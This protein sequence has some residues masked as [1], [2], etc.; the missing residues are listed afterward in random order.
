[1]ETGK[2]EHLHAALAAMAHDKRFTQ[3]DYHSAIRFIIEQAA[4]EIGCARVS[5][6]A[7]EASPEPQIT[8]L[9]LWSEGA[10]QGAGTVL[11]H[12]E[13]SSYLASLEKDVLLVMN[14]VTC[15]PRCRELNRAYLPD[16][17]ILSMMDAPFQFDGRLAGVICFE[18]VGRHRTW[19]T[20]EQ[21]FASSMASLLSIATERHHRRELETRLQEE[22]GR[23]QMLLDNAPVGIIIVVDDHLAYANKTLADLAGL[24]RTDDLIGVP[25]SAFLPGDTLTAARERINELTLTRSETVSE[26]TE[27]KVVFNGNEYQLEMTSTYINWRGRDAVQS[28]IRDVT[29]Q[30]RAEAEAQETATRLLALIDSFPGGFAYTDTSFTFL[31]VNE[32]LAG[33]A[34]MTPEQMV[35]VPASEL[36]TSGFLGET[37]NHLRRVMAGEAV[38]FERRLNLPGDPMEARIYLVPHFDEAN[39]IR[40]MFT[41]VTDIRELRDTEMALRQA[42]K[43]EAVGQLTGGIAHDFNNILTIVMGNLEVLGTRIEGTDN[44]GLVEDALTGARRGAE[45]TRKLLGFS[46]T[47]TG[48]VVITD[49]NRRVDHLT[50]LLSQTLTKSINIRLNLSPT[51]AP[52]RLDPGDLDDALL[53]LMLNARDAMNGQGTMTIS[54]V[55]QDHE[56]VLSIA[57]EGVGMTAEM[58]ER[59]FDP[60]HSTKDESEGTGLGLSMVYGFVQRAGGRIHVESEPGR[61]ARFDLVFPRATDATEA[62]SISA[63]VPEVSTS[64]KRIV[65]VEDEPM[66]AEVSSLILEKLGYVTTVFASGKE[67]LDYIESGNDADLLFTDAILGGEMNGFE[68]AELVAEARPGLKMLLTSGFNTSDMHTE[69][70]LARR[71]TRHQLTK[72]Y[73]QAAL[74]RAVSDTLSN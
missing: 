27:Y 16:H 21:H 25:I 7:Y 53:N 41:L 1:M 30:R 6:W 58:R 36:V 74:A 55:N 3:G 65:V 19:S 8:C 43:M 42:Q 61:G 17:N 70:A 54:T 33:W 28:I 10:H 11:T 15:D 4:R 39:Q 50:E 69:S 13:A 18:N 48:G 34:G 52:V 46:R 73:D 45:L 9:T 35:G 37:K 40:G 24:A 31:Q 57:D 51:L 59:I 66:V 47:E 67:A 38:T 49:I 20:T 14:D 60:F 2:F 29:S 12:A 32:T 68:L 71:L 63:G 23:H 64:K 62:I 44:A 22:Q 72:P 56:V 5:A 26:P